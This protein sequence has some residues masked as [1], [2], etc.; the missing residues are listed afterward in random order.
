MSPRSSIGCVK[1]DF[2]AYD[3]FS[4]NRATILHQDLHYLEMDRN[5]LPLEPRH[6]VV[7]SGA[8]KMIF[9][10]MVRLVQTYTYLAP[11]LTTSPNEPKR[12]STYPITLEF[13]QERPKLF[14]SLWYV[15]RK[16][17]TYRA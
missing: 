13:H 15:Q 8:S 9:E 5:K 11:T 16:P 17:R 10:P 14:M 3:T 7:P 6:L 4:T 1:N 2:L 12:G